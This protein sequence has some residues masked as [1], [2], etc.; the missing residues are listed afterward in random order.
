MYIFIW[1]LFLQTQPPNIRLNSN[2]FNVKRWRWLAMAAA[3]KQIFI[4]NSGTFFIIAHKFLYEFHM[5]EVIRE[6]KQITT[7]I[8]LAKFHL[9]SHSATNF[10]FIL[11]GPVDSNKRISNFVMSCD[12]LNSSY[13]VESAHKLP[14][15]VWNA[16]ECGYL[17]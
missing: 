8:S 14:H 2:P 3:S 4:Q 9:L 10:L 12:I 13:L 5:R 6:R 15:N 16:C 1:P 17:F 7:I 11:V